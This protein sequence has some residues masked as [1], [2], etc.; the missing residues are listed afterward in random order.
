[1]T[2]SRD[3]SSAARLRAAGR[4]FR[5]N[6][7]WWLVPLVVV[8]LLLLAIVSLSPSHDAPFIYTGS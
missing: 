2:E 4:F 3:G 6:L 1:M 7:R 5:A 8:L